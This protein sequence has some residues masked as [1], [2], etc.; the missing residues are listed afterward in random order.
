[1]KK[2]SE[3]RGEK[4]VHSCFI[5]FLSKLLFFDVPQLVQPYIQ[6]CTKKHPETYSPTLITPIL[7][8]PNLCTKHK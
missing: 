8:S 3:K 1:M 5:D 2:R 4:N 6:E 7:V